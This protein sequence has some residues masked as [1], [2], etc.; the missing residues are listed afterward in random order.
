M[1]RLHALVQKRFYSLLLIL[2]AGGFLVVLA[3]LILANHTRGIQLVA[4]VAT[5]LGLLLAGAGI[6]ASEK[7]RSILAVLFLLL[8]VTGV[9]GVIEHNEGRLE[10]GV[11]VIPA[12]VAEASGS[13]SH[14]AQYSRDGG[15]GE[16]E[17]AESGGTNTSEFGEGGERGE[18]GERGEEPAPPLAPL[19]LAGL[20]LIGATVLAG[21]KKE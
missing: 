15:E 12:Q 21:Y 8:S 6:V 7:A 18:R 5:V 1:H 20:S 14:T 17:A 19:S 16:N 11:T 4:V 13:P 2:V 3:E 9:V 10:E